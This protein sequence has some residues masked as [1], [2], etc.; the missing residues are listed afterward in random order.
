MAT[1]RDHLALVF[2][3]FISGDGRPRLS[4]AL[5]GVALPVLDPFLSGN[6]ATQQSHEESFKVQGESVRVKAFTLPFLTKM[7]RRDRETALVAGSLRDSQGFYI[8]RAG[9]LVIWGDWFRLEKR[10]DMSKLARVRVDIPN[11]LD[12]L[13]SLDI[14]KSAAIPPPAV[15]AQLKKLS[16]RMVKPSKRVQTFRGR[17]VNDPLT[18][19]WETVE[20]R[21]GFRYK[22]NRSHPAVLAM[23]RRLDA[24]ARASFEVLL[25]SLEGSFPV[26]DAHN[27][28][29]QDQVPAPEPEPG[30]AAL[31]QARDLL[32]VH[33]R[34]GGTVEDFVRD[35]AGVEP[36][37]RIEN[38]SAK[39]RGIEDGAS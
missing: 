30:A 32:A 12:H 6:R 8:Y 13:W 4:I 1:A 36:L 11:S 21:D 26:F 35:F 23:Q 10:S 34:L 31:D 27:R 39:L 3:R 2:H 5:N 25:V 37:N 17:P 29:S 28:L 20:G 19:V 33:E 18:R 7:S 22:V 9:R 38:L 15:R 24:E 16:E 14:K